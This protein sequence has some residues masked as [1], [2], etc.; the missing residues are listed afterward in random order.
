MEVETG[1]DFVSDLE[2]SRPN[3]RKEN[4]SNTQTGLGQDS[5]L[6]TNQAGTRKLL[7]KVP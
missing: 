5:L 6:L 3:L 1:G 4:I 7:W 2:N